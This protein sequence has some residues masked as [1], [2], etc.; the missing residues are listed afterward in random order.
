MTEEEIEKL[1]DVYGPSLAR[2]NVDDPQSRMLLPTFA[3]HIE[4]AT[5]HRCYRI[6]MDAANKMDALGTEG[7]QN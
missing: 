6:A 3:R 7:G 2:I 4:R 5:R 1:L